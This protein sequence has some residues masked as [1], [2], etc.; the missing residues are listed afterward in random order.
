MFG[1]WNEPRG[2]HLYGVDHHQFRFGE[3]LALLIDGEVYQSRRS[4]STPA[5]QLVPIWN[6]TSADMAIGEGSVTARDLLVRWTFPPSYADLAHLPGWS[7][8]LPDL[9]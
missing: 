7:V 3:R 8:F 9:L 5:S 4:P 2:R 1:L 6:W